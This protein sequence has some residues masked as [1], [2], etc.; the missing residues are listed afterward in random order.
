MFCLAGENKSCDTERRYKY[1]QSNI[2]ETIAGI[3]GIFLMS[4]DH[5]KVFG[6]KGAPLH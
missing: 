4:L 6:F 5:A 2:A 1:S 3:L